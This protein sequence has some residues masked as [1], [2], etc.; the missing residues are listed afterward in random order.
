MVTKSGRAAL[1]MF[2]L[3]FI[4]FVTLP[5]SAISAV[6]NGSNTD[7][8]IRDVIAEAVSS[9]I[10][11]CSVVEDMIRTGYN[12][13]ETVENAI[14]M[15]NPPCVVVRCAVEAGGKVE[16][17]VTAAFRAGATP[18]VVVTCC[19][20][21]GA[22]PEILARTIDRFCSPGFGYTP[23]VQSTGYTPSYSPTVSGA[24]GGESVSRFRP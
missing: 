5:S 9:G 23:P 11:I 8:P 14:L 3:L 24:G 6:R 21:G 12:V 16:D 13:S 19:M 18:D 22:S 4:Q 15:G 10:R 7:R 17:V 20:E 2:L 1:I